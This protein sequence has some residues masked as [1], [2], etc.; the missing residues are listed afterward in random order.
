M[1]PQGRGARGAV[2]R[3][4]LIRK[5][6][7]MGCAMLRHGR[8]HDWYQNPKSKMCQPVPR[9]REIRD[10]LARH[11]IRMLSPEE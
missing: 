1:R 4:A 2:K 10:H 7:Q 9:H 3:V 11:I 6:E 8:R 5:L